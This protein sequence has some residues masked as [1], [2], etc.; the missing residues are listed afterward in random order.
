MIQAIFSS[1]GFKLIKLD[2]SVVYL[3]FYC[4]QHSLKDTDIPTL[5]LYL[6]PCRDKDFRILTD[7]E[8]NLSQ[9]GALA[10]LKADSI[11]GCIRS[12]MAAERE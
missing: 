2:S 10:A 8:L 7:E 4:S 3:H 6:Q 11:L 5:H 12:G 9:K 1:C